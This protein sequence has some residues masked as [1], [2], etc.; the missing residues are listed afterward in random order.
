MR[1]ADLSVVMANRNHARL[2]PRAL[3]AVLSQSLPP[4]E[5]IVLDDA[6]TD[7]SLKV[8]ERYAARHPSVRLVKNECHR[9]VTASYNHGFAL[10]TGRYVL[11]GAA[12]DYV[13]PGFVAKAV[14]EFERHPQAGVCV[15]HGSCTDGDDGPLVVNDP[16][17]CDQPTY[18]APDD[19]CRR[20]WH[21]LPV[22]AI[23][24]RADAV[25]AA[26]GYRSELAW[27]SDWFAFLVVAF[28]HGAVHIPETLGVHVLHRGS[29]ATNS[30]P[31][32]ENVRILGALLDLLVSPEY[33]DVSPYFRRNGAA[34]H[35][36]PDL[37]RAAALRADRRE[38]NVLGLL[39]GFAPEV[40]ESLAASDEDPAVRELAAVFL[41]DPWREVIARRADLEA[42]NRRLVEEIQLTRLRAAPPGVMGK[43]QW[44]GGMI[45][46][47]LRTAVGLHP[48]GRFR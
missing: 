44:A 39:A 2:L 4:R 15:A 24:V 45:R 8:L 30:R 26:G 43:V 10:A 27:Y 22:S 46:R 11:P 20:V 13:L 47:R 6:S 33:A 7:D 37:L 5:V 3:D 29:Y 18:F 21:T 19:V 34:C 17:W 9:G 36:G 14:R 32:A 42:E 38:A 41:Q 28:R 16:G 48:A 35:F 25:R 40:Y 12:D 1:T 31:G 23:V